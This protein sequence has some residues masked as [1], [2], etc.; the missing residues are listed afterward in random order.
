MPYVKEIILLALL[1]YVGH[2]CFSLLLFDIYNRYH[3]NTCNCGEQVGPSI[4]SAKSPAQSTGVA[5]VPP[6]TRNVIQ[7]F[8]LLNTLYKAILEYDNV[9]EASEQTVYCISA[10]S[11]VHDKK[12]VESLS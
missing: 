5:E 1:L 6:D 12:V 4:G 2:R 3:D 9:G 8:L 7:V 11:E 10:L